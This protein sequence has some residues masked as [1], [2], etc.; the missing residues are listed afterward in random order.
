MNAKEIMSFQRFRPEACV[1]K[2]TREIAKEMLSSS[3]GN[4]RLRDWYVA[5]LAASMVRGEW[6][7]TSQG[8]GFDS[9]GHLIDAHHRL[10]ACV[11]SGIPFE[12]VVVFGLRPDAYQVIDV[13]MKRTTSD[14][15]N[16]PKDIGDTLRL[17]TQYAISNSKP[18]ADQIIP[19]MEAGLLDA[20]EALKEF[21]RSHTKYFA[22]APMKLAA[23]ISVMNGEDAGYVLDQY[24]ALCTLDFDKMSE[25]AK[26]LCRQV[27]SNKADANDSRETLARGL[28]VF[29]KSKRNITKIQ[30][31][32]GDTNDAVQLVKT[33][34]L[35]AVA[36]HEKEYRSRVKNGAHLMGGAA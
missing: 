1:M 36:A 20:A 22:S 2:I 26:A 16:V 27:Q 30:I 25:S 14:L 12:S 5:L 13:G 29:K 28:R 32:D 8:I 18:T 10:N 21:H 4:R 9:L 11:K 35:N 6:R 17:G 33:V 3:A 15:L 19:F 34:L 24:K 23:C 31:S 7:V